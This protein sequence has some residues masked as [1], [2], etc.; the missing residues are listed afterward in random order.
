MTSCRDFRPLLGMFAVDRLDEAETAELHAHLDT[1]QE[2]WTDLSELC[3]V[4]EA[5]NQLDLDRLA[6]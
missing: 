1:C 2:C 5:L 6:P 4:V 3:G